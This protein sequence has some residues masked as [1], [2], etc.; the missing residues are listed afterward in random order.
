MSKLDLK[1]HVNEQIKNTFI[2]F[3]YHFVVAIL[4]Y[5]YSQM[6]YNNNFFYLRFFILFRAD[7][8]PHMCLN[9]LVLL[10]L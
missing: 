5:I 6:L 1:N 3:F 10:P 7:K 9:L 2:Y 4:F 8:Y